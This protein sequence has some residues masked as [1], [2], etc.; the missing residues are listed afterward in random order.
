MVTD[1]PKSRLIS[2]DIAE[3]W[4]ECCYVFLQ[5]D[6][7]KNNIPDPSLL[8]SSSSPDKENKTD[9]QSGSEDYLA[10]LC[11]L[12]ARWALW[13]LILCLKR[14]YFS[15]YQIVICISELIDLLSKLSFCWSANI[16]A[17][18]GTNKLA[19]KSYIFFNVK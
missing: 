17:Y 3:C 9:N 11:F 2:I 10:N 18:K 15:Y 14:V 5:V 7:L 6:L 19:C 13:S 12:H 4:N 16:F 8:T 1:D